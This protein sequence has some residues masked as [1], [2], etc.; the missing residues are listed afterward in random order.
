[1]EIDEPLA[2]FYAV[3][4]APGS[5]FELKAATLIGLEFLFIIYFISIKA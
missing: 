3:L 1:M 5:F 4:F 2:T